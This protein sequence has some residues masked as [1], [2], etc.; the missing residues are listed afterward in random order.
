MEQYKSTLDDKQI[1]S[2]EKERSCT[3]L[4]R[5]GKIEKRNHAQMLH[6]LG[7]PKRPV[8]GYLLFKAEEHKKGNETIASIGAKWLSFSWDEKEKYNEK[9]REALEE[10]K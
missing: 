5:V 2:I 1:Q 4:K 3:E 7:K 10:Y 9:A 6:E 8:N